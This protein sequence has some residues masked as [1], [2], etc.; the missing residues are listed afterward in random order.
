MPEG[1][2]PHQ[3]SP[4]LRPAHTEPAVLAPAPKAAV[5]QATP[6]T[7]KQRQ[8]TPESSGLEASPHQARPDIRTN[9]P[10]VRA[11]IASE[12]AIDTSAP[13]VPKEQ[14]GSLERAKK[15]K[16]Q[17]TGPA[18]RSGPIRVAPTDVT[19]S[20]PSK[21]VAASPPPEGPGAAVDPGTTPTKQV[22]R[23]SREHQAVHYG[24]CRQGH[25]RWRI[26]LSSKP[27]TKSPSP[28]N[29]TRVQ[30]PPRA[31]AFKTKDFALTVP[32]PFSLREAF[33]ANEC[34][35]S[36]ALPKKHET[37]GTNSGT[38]QGSSGGGEKSK[39]AGGEN[40]TA[41]PSNDSGG[42]RE[43]DM[44]G[45]KPNKPP[46]MNNMTFT[47]SSERVRLTST[48]RPRASTVDRVPW[49][50]SPGI[51]GHRVDFLDFTRPDQT[52]SYGNGQMVYVWRLQLGN[53][54]G[55]D[56]KLCATA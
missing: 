29:V 17:I 20:K 16:K 53:F 12:E 21:N 2:Q 14:R 15:T 28:N 56:N 43:S 11:S 44:L 39:A 18:V 23:W 46:R 45:A 7:P 42:V 40:M 49:A 33:A 22:R 50:Q 31:T 35:G 5:A 30:G 51:N 6:P 48:L 19:L 24:G 13:L 37:P 36:P 26:A 34:C 32:L 1:A 38:G 27:P 9:S 25:Q 4:L 3:P 54:I 8:E 41:R 52:P 47:K 55:S 10:H